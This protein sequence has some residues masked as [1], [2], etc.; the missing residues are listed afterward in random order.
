ME[1]K[2]TEKEVEDYIF[3]KQGLEEYHIKCVGRQVQMGDAGIVDI[4]GWDRWN[5]TWVIVEIKRDGLDAR[6]YTQAERYRSWLHEYM[7]ARSCKRRK[8]FNP[9]YTLLIG[10]DLADDL[11]FAKDLTDHF[12]RTA[13]NDFYLIYNIKP[14]VQLGRF[15][16]KSARQYREKT[17]VDI[18][19]RVS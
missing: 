9:P 10:T 14:Q 1:I 17:Q 4:L 3:E 11:R 2:L 7:D 16:S 15:V 6:A 18:D 5:N 8:T 19:G 13:M 12:D